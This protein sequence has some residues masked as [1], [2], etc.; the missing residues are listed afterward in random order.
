MTASPARLWWHLHP[1][2]FLGAEPEALPPGSP[3]V[4]RLPRLQRWLEHAAGLGADGLL[5]GPV[6][7]SG[8]HGYDTVDYDRVDPRLGDADDLAALVAAARERGMAVALDGVFNHV[9]RGF[10]PFQEVLR[11]G[12]DSEF[13]SWFRLRWPDGGWAGPGSE[14]GYDTFEG[15]GGLVALQHSEPAVRDMLSGVL[16]RWAGLGV[17]AWRLDAAYAVQPEVLRDL[18][19]RAREQRPGSWFLGEVI[20]GDYA[21]VAA[22]SGLDAVTQ[23][24]LWKALWSSLNDRNLYELA[25]ALVRHQDFATTMTP[26]TFVGNHDVTR[27][28]SR[29]PDERHLQHAVAVLFTLASVPSVYAGDEHGLH[30]EKEE[31]LGGDDA[32]RPAF[33]DDPLDLAPEVPGLF[34]LHADLAALRREHPWLEHC[35]TE[36]RDLANQHLSYLSS[37][38]GGERLLVV[39]SLADDALDLPAPGPGWAVVRGAADVAGD[40]VAVAPHGWAVLAPA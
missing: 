22:A 18:T 10:G 3:V 17:T 35:R 13:A 24:E 27:I 39:L 34:Q 26:Q 12:P 23:Y 7:A 16:D 11:H 14:P 8:S 19:T 38:P 2:T 31:R 32:I 37:G 15:H 40:R 6:F 4:H 9:G 30:G 5:L 1:L 33:P 36:V 21:A 28:A 20:H 29:L 25:H